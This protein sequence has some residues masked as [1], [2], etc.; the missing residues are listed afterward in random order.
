V[1]PVLK[2]RDLYGGSQLLSELLIGSTGQF[3]NFC[4]M[5]SKDFEHLLTLIEPAIGKQDTNYIKAISSKE[6]L[7]ITLRFLASGDS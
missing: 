2:S 6:R 1:T 3:E 4:R 7:A 5:S